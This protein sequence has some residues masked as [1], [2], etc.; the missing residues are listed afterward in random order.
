MVDYPVSGRPIHV[1]RSSFEGG[2]LEISEEWGLVSR[3]FSMIM[4][5][6]VVSVIRQSAFRWLQGLRF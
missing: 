4:L 2:G 6:D 5:D 3:D 1:L